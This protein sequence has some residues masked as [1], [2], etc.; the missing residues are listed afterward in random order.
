MGQEEAPKII[1]PPPE[2][3]SIVEKTA[4][5]V[6]TRGGTELEQRIKENERSNPKFAFLND[7]DPYH[8]YY[9]MRVEAIK[10][11]AAPITDDANGLMTGQEDQ[12]QPQQDANIKIPKEPPAY[13]FFCATPA[14][15][16][17]EL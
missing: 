1:Y 2:I 14:I 3:R 15:S 10:N 13:D 8:A 11:G 9:Q 17:Q 4:T 16:V 6:A 7:G 12:P 5:F